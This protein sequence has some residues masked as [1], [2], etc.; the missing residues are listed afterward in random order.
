MFSTQVARVYYLILFPTKE[1]RPRVYHGDAEGTEEE[2]ENAGRGE[3]A[4][5][6]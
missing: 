5:E 4:R 3:S 2:E 1:M 6:R